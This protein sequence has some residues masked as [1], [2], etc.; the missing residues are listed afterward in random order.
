MRI[1]LWW[2]FFL[3]MGRALLAAFVFTA[4]LGALGPLEAVSQDGLVTVDVTGDLADFALSRFHAR[5]EHE[6]AKE[7]PVLLLSA[8]DLIRRY[9]PEPSPFSSA[10]PGPPSFEAQVVGALISPEFLH[11]LAGQFQGRFLE[12]LKKRALEQLGPDKAALFLELGK[13]WTRE[14]AQCVDSAARGETGPETGP[15]AGL[16]RGD[17]AYLRDWA[18]GVLAA[19]SEQK[20]V[21]ATAS[22]LLL[23]LATGFSQ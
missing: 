15:P 10:E 9:G 13:A 6:L 2:R 12:V 20:A 18:R 23:E 16:P 22:E 8:K 14:L 7:G 17:C 19:N 11:S 3:N 21:L 4:G 1:S 5:G